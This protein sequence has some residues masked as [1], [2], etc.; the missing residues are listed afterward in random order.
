M[1]RRRT[2]AIGVL[3]MVLGTALVLWWALRPPPLDERRAAFKSVGFD[4]LS[5]WSDDGQHLALQAF[6]RSCSRLEELAPNLPVGPVEFGTAVRDWLE[7]CVTAGRIRVDDPA[8]AR[9]FFETEF[10]PVAVMRGGET[11]GLFTG[12]YEPI[13]EGSRQRIGRFNIPLYGRPVD[14]VTANL[15]EFGPEWSGIQLVG[16]LDDGKLKPFDTRAAI[17]SGELADRAQPIM[18]LRSAVDAFFLHIQGAGR[19]RLNDGTETRVGYAAN[20]GHPYTAIG[21]ELVKLGALPEDGVSM[22]SIRRWLEANPREAQGVMFANDRYIFFREIEGDGPLGAGQVVLTPGRSLA[23]D[24]TLVPLHLP[25]WL[26]TSL[27]LEEEE[28]KGLTLRRLMIAQDTGAAI[29]GLVRG[30]IFWG[31]GSLA[32]EIAGQM[33]AVGRY[34]LLLPR[35]TRE[36]VLA[37]ATGTN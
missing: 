24:T 33:S 2:T 23:V 9:L 1:N 27:P 15:S 19:V 14:L 25:V 5:G 35:G 11:E 32:A 13:F 16:R 22:Q 7:P 36:K 26:E 28:S 4:Q 3:L 10:E 6:L 34:Y 18:W 17:E 29:R 31:S 30:D 21:K 12:Y 20:N 8:E 37:A